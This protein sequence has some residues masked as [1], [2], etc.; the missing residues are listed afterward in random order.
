MVHVGR[1]QSCAPAGEI[2]DR[3]FCLRRSP[4]RR[5]KGRA[6]ALSPSRALK[7]RGLQV[8]PTNSAHGLARIESGLRPWRG[9]AN[10]VCR[11]GNS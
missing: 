9:I 4:P 2:R 5:C 1:F 7:A 3:G 10:G 8:R 6:S 11:Q